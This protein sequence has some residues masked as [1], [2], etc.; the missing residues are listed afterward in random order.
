MNFEVVM[1]WLVIITCNFKS[2]YLFCLF[3]LFYFNFKVPT[4][5]F[6]LME[7]ISQEI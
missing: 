1:G 4:L 3:A 6:D 2:L 7:H 5:W